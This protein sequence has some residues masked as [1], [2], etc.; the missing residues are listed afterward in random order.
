M[1]A[2]AVRIVGGP[3]EHDYKFVEVV[4]LDAAANA[5]TWA[6]LDDI[7]KPQGVLSRGW[8]V[9]DEPTF[10]AVANSVSGTD[11]EYEGVVGGI[12]T[13]PRGMIVEGGLVELRVSRKRIKK[14]KP[15]APAQ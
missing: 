1:V 14:E 2:N 9:K 3:D 5:A 6:H 4:W 13:I 8:L 11:G 15:D 7:V 10:I 12:I